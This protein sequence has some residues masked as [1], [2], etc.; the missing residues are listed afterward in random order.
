MN[1]TDQAIVLTTG[2]YGESSGIVSLITPEFGLHKGLVRGISSKRN[3]GIY[4]TGNQ[5]EATWKGRLPENLGYFIAELQSANAANIMQ[6]PDRLAA[7]NCICIMLTSTLA[8]R[9]PA[10]KI[11]RYLQ[12]FIAY[13]KESNRWVLY[14][15]LFEIELL[16]HIGFSLSLSSCVST[17][18]TDNLFYISPKSGCAVSKKAGDP[19][20]N[21]LLRLP[22]FILK[23]VNCD[24]TQQDIID[25]LKITSYFFEKHHFIP[26][27][28]SVPHARTY[29]LHLLKEVKNP[30]N[31]FVSII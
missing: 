17:G 11:Y 3:C 23:G 25:G 12:E 16:A 7:L 31:S 1:W 14:Y 5:I 18:S 30:E 27:N 6:Y 9:E 15:I 4:Q 29:F 26:H 8:E 22:D 19:Y 28:L 13:L 10:I 24:Y 20:K 2:K 21:K